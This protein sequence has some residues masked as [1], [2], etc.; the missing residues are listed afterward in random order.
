MLPE[1]CVAWGRSKNCIRELSEYGAARKAEIG[2]ENVFDYS[3]G[4]PSIPAPDTVT[5][6]MRELL[7]TAMQRMRVETIVVAEEEQ[8]DA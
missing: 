3:I 8:E 6:T 5:D 4:S 7:A 1:K 2:P